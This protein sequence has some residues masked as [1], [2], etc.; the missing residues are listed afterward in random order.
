MTN[1]DYRAMCAELADALA[2]WRL[3]GGPP[4]DTADAELVARAR[5]LLA[6][7]EAE[8]PTDQELLHLYQVATPCY[9]VEEYKRELDFARA[10]LARWGRP[11]TAPVPESTDEALANFT[12]WFCR[13]YP[14]PD[15]LI[16]R[17]EWHAPKVFRAASDALARW[18]RPTPQPPADG[19][20]AELVE[21]LHRRAAEVQAENCTTIYSPHLLRRVAD[22]LGQT[23]PERSASMMDYARQCNTQAVAALVALEV[24][25]DAADQFGPAGGADGKVL[26]AEVKKARG[27]LARTLLAEADGPAVP[28]DREPASVA[29]QPSDAEIMELMPQQMHDDLAAAARA[30]AEQE[31][32]DSTPAKGVLRII[33]N[34]HVVDLARAA[35]SRWGRPAPQPVPVSER[36]PE[37]NVKVLAYYFNALG[38]G[39]TICAIWV[40]AKSRSDEGDDF[41]E[42]DEEGDKYY[43]PEGWY[44]AIENWDE[45][46][47]A[48]VY[49]G[50]IVYWQPLP[51]WPANALPTPEA[52]ND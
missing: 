35:L 40:P 21:W 23:E 7:P 41:L 15:T 22:L 2:E 30:M 27:V 45:L 52:T 9:S 3:G 26:A 5:A 50:E 19:E 34:R 46:G 33:L 24:L 36:L 4:E 32:I 39:R 13:N 29:T 42:Y 47:W 10:V 14:G 6:E 51:K 18:G 49:E 43:W 38:K 8:G 17:P 11:V 31:G 1:P 25:A 37:P 20:V 12:A 28:N 48:K 16:H 44:E